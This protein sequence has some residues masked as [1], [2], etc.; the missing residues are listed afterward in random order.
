MDEIVRR[1]PRGKALNIARD[2]GGSVAKPCNP[3]KLK[4]IEPQGKQKIGIF[5][6]GQVSSRIEAVFSP[7]GALALDKCSAMAH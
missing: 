3:H 7:G 6:S 1:S 2:N 5:L 4:E